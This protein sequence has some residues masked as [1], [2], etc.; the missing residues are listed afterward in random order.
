L[1]KYFFSLFYLTRPKSFLVDDYSDLKQ[2]LSE[3]SV[4][5]LFLILTKVSPSLFFSTSHNS[6]KNFLTS[7][8]S[9]KLAESTNPADSKSS[10]PAADTRNHIRPEIVA[11]KLNNPDEAKTSIQKLTEQNTAMRSPSK[12][13]QQRSKPSKSDTLV[14]P[15]LHQIPN[16]VSADISSSSS[17]LTQSNSSNRQ[18]SSLL[19]A[20]TMNY[21]R[22]QQPD[23]QTDH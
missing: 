23:K 19:D 11:N 18:D 3:A 22:Q 5:F 20:N 12:K 2:I 8:L 13:P 21:N 9:A 15:S 17:S 1:Y 16:P 6:K 4:S 7:L 14:Y 10:S